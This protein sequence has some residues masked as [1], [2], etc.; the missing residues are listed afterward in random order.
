MRVLGIAGS[1]AEDSKNHRL[2][3]RARTLAPAG[4]RLVIFDGLGA[5][6]IMH[7]DALAGPAPAPVQRFRDA[8]DAARAVLIA[9]PEYSHSLPGVLKNAIDWVVQSGELHRKTVAI[10]AAV[11][12][13][14]RGQRGLDALEIALGGV[15]ARV[16]ADTPIALDGSEDQR[17]R[18]LLGALHE[19]G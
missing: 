9:T 5:I 15:G 19:V 7:P 6:P 2:L 11:R 10:T 16:L 1:L 18:D 12:D 3:E 8:L 14:S 13:P 4:M 17:L